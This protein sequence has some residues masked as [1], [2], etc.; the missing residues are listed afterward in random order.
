MSTPS[1]TAL[2]LRSHSKMRRSQSADPCIRFLMLVWADCIPYPL[3]P[4]LEKIIRGQKLHVKVYM[5]GVEVDE[6]AIS[7]GLNQTS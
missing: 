5:S 3:L 6:T 2:L 7:A 4:L 1:L